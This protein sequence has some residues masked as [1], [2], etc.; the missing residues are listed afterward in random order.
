MTGGSKIDT[1][2]RLGSPFFFPRRYKLQL[3]TF[4]KNIL[5]NCQ[6]YA[7]IKNRSKC[8]RSKTVL[9]VEPDLIPLRI[10]SNSQKGVQHSLY[11]TS[12]SQQATGF[13]KARQLFQLKKSHRLNCLCKAKSLLLLKQ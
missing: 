9:R 6:T 8:K 10:F 4:K 2:I 3:L 1:T 5:I 13:V 11:S 12:K 7:Y